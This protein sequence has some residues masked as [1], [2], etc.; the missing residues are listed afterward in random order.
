MQ[1]QFMDE[2]FPFAM[3]ICQEQGQIVDCNE[4]FKQQFD[5]QLDSAATNNIIE[6]LL[7]MTFPVLSAS[8]TS[9]KALEGNSE[10]VFMFKHQHGCSR[11]SV[12]AKF[13]EKNSHY[14][15]L[16]TPQTSDKPCQYQFNQ[17]IES[18]DIGVWQLDLTSMKFNCSTKMKQLLKLELSHEVSW[19][20][21]VE[22]VQPSDRYK[23]AGLADLSSLNESSCFQFSMSHQPH[24]IFELRAKHFEFH[25]VSSV[26]I[27]LVLDKTES[28]DMLKDL[29]ALYEARDLALDAGN[30]GN[31][32]S[33]VDD[34]G[35]WKWNWDMRANDMCGI[36]PHRR[37]DLNA[38][39]ERLHPEDSER[40]FAALEHSL[41]TGEPFDQEYR[42][43]LDGPQTVYIVAKGKVGK[44]EFNQNTRIDGVCIDQ[45]PIIKAQLALKESNN[46][47]ES[48][49]KQRTVELQR[50]K[51]L[52][53]RA[54]QAKSEFLSMIS[55]EL[56][57]PMNAVIGAL[58]LLEFTDDKKE[59]KELIDTASTSANNLIYILNDIL[60]INKIESGKMDVEQAD[61]SIADI[62]LNLQQLFAPTAHRHNLDFIIQ[63]APEIPVLL[64]GDSV[65]VRQI[66]YNLLSNAMKFT[67]TRDGNQGVV[68][69]KVA[70]CEQNSVVTRVR[71]TVS[72][73]G[74]GIDKQTQ[75][76]LFTPFV[77]AQKS[78]TR[79]YGGTGLGLAICGK[80]TNLLAGEIKLESTPGKGS[81]FSVEIPF[82]PA[83]STRDNQTL[84]G[85][86]VA[87]V[88]LQGQPL[89]QDWIKAYLENAGATVENIPL[90]ALFSAEQHYDAT[91]VLSHDFSYSE[92]ELTQLFRQNEHADNL[93]V[94]TPS[95]NKEKLQNLLPLANHLNPFPMCQAQL[96][97]A[98]HDA[99]TQRHAIDLDNLDLCFED[100]IFSEST[101]QPNA[102]PHN[103]CADI[104]VVEDNPLNQKLIVKQLK[105]L[106]YQCDLAGDGVDGIELWQNEH[107]KLILTD[108]HMPNLDGYDMSKKIRD[109]EAIANKQAIP[110]VAITGAA[111]S[112]ELDYCYESGMNDFVSKPIQLRDLEKVMQRWY[113]H[114]AS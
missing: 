15:L 58:E 72:D 25:K 33:E 66:L 88:G 7:P 91:L 35:N 41:K 23:L 13:D 77:Q 71:F 79:E 95:K 43:V 98:I 44:N 61:F 39:V 42:I 84:A 104:L 56:R 8:V 62:V 63:E 74:I 48:R 106:G 70:I 89:N 20:T 12:S 30:I 29:K 102:L 94:L 36:A 90:N 9:L 5:Y 64:E 86:H 52:A 51:E 54:S 53:E 78:T 31:W 113:S 108:C 75:K 103:D 1:Y 37:G 114:E 57:T 96:I 22:S 69:L 97:Q 27:G 73:T 46:N 21:F 26:L 11:V 55:H 92:Q 6:Q 16:F 100:E 40:V 24:Q 10:S 2:A 38:W 19:Q 34:Q 50:A 105:T 45:S 3:L 83:K 99:I 14:L 59:T 85:N 101:T 18:A 49:V 47:L 67:H 109:L 60:D 87:L 28:N 111:M 4:A 112:T 68:T 82:W 17:L 65:K 32:H 107:Y 81:S 80:L 76:Q 93:V 110:I